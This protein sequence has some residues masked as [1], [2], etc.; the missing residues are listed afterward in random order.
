[1]YQVLPVDDEPLIL[2]GIKFMLDWNKNNCQIAG[3]ARNGQQAME[4]IRT[5]H[6]DIV[7]CD[8]AMPGMTGTE[9]LQQTAKEFP[10]VV[11]IMLTNHPDFQMAQHSLRYRAVDYLLKS[12]LEPE[13]LERSLAAAQAE[14]R[15]R[16]K[17]NR[18]EMVDDY[19]E[20][21]RQN[22]LEKA[23]LSLM[24]SQ[25]G[26]ANENAVELLAENGALQNYAIAYLVMDFSAVSGWKDFS[27][28]ERAKTFEWVRELCREVAQNTFPENALFSA[29]TPAQSQTLFLLCWQLETEA[30]KSRLRIFAEKA[31][32]ACR[33]IAKTELAVMG[34]SCFAGPESL[35]SCRRQLFGLRDNYYYFGSNAMFY[36]DFAP[37]KWGSLALGGIGDRLQTE[38][39]AKNAAACELL[40]KRAIDRVST[41]PH[42]QS[43][44]LWLCGGIYSA[45][46]AFLEIDTAKGRQSIEQLATRQQVLEWLELIK[47]EL[48]ARMGQCD[49]A[50]RTALLEKAR[51]YVLDNVD[52]R[53]MLQDV[54]DHICIS[55]GYLSALFKKQYDQTLVEFI[56]E[57]KCRRA[58][59]L[60]RQG[61]YRIYEISYMLGF[62]NAYYFT[63]VFKRYLGM[64]PTEY[65]KKHATEK[66]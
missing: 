16:A 34:T 36:E 39:N 17:L 63:R 6:P 7:I 61:Q 38:I 57:Q 22:M 23:F 65:Q 13:A 45:A 27:P 40:L 11:F 59:E 35:E 53:I 10:H 33:T 3:T 48:S 30:W 1:M 50:G 64:T 28:E 15:T 5:L 66:G 8:I 58:S 49:L 4:K 54:A 20:H 32:A 31:G 29:N 25:P 56:N 21:N 19:L 26:Y 2:S 47:T 60:I 9:L 41:V 18:V 12:D 37:V 46:A 62:E 43:Q 24:Q 51:Q 42:Q 55:P 52:K 44:A 14:C